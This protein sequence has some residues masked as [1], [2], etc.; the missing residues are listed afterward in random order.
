MLIDPAI[1]TSNVLPP[2][3]KPSLKP[4][5]QRDDSL[6]SQSWIEDLQFKPQL[7]SLLTVST[8]KKFQ[9]N[10]N[11]YNGHSISYAS[12]YLALYENWAANSQKLFFLQMNFL[13]NSV[14]D[15]HSDDSNLNCQ[16]VNKKRVHN[17]THKRF[18]EN[19]LFNFKK[20]H[21]SE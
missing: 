13:R 1:S 11:Q 19:L 21:L 5:L 10:P 15:L 4:D 3:L 20:N 8:P 6:A 16:S 12:K 7:T 2:T 18:F 17:E 9:I 14:F